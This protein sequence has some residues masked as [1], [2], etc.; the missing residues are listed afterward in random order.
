[1]VGQNDDKSG[2]VWTNHILPA[3]ASG[4]NTAY[5][6]VCANPFGEVY[7]YIEDAR[8]IPIED[9]DGDDTNSFNLNMD[10]VA[11]TEIAN[12]DFPN[13]NNASKGVAEAFTFTGTAAQRRIA[14]NDSVLI[15]REEVGTQPARI[16]GSIVQI[17]WRPDGLLA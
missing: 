10:L 7:A 16:F 8:Y 9:V 2:I 17:A 15:E 4:G 1:M 3:V 6:C 5:E 11:G 12:L 14:P 13:S